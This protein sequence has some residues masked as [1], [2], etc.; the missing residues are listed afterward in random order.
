MLLITLRVYATGGMLQT[1]GDLFG[2]SK[3]TVSKVVTLVS[4][5]I[6]LLRARFIKFPES[7]TEKL[8]T[9]KGFFKIAKFP[10]VIAALD[11]THIRII[12]PGKNF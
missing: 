7:D 3:S 1:I 2:I 8:K 12:S 4:H 11:C 6:A 10:T 9:Y 5:H